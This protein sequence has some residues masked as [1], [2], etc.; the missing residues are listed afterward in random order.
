MDNVKTFIPKADT[1]LYRRE[2]ELMKKIMSLLDEYEYIL[3]NAAVIGAL[4]L[5]KS[6]VIK[7]A[8]EDEDDD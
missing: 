5:A 4:E 6:S 3:S 2:D 8:Y 7:D 1:Q